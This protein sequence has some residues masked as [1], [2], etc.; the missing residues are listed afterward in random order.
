[1]RDL[2]GMSAPSILVECGFL[3]GVVAAAALALLFSAP[4][5]R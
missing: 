5:V 3:V 2:L 1:M 4:G